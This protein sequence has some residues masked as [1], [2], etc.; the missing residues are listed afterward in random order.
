MTDDRE[1]VDREAPTPPRAMS[2]ARRMLAEFEASGGRPPRRPWR[3][4][5]AACIAVAAIGVAAVVGIHLLPEPPPPTVRPSPQPPMLVPST[6]LSAP[7]DRREEEAQALFAQATE[8]AEA[9]RWREAARL[10]DRLTHAFSETACVARLRPA[11]ARLRATVELELKPKPATSVAVLPPP[12][13]PLPEPQEITVAAALRGWPVAFDDPL[14]SKACL[15]RAYLFKGQYGGHFH[16]HNGGLAVS[17]VHTNSALWW[18]CAVG[19]RWLVSLDFYGQKG[20]PIVLL[21]GPGIGSHPAVGYALHL[22]HE[23]GA[24]G[25]EL[26]RQGALLGVPL[27]RALFDPT[28]WHHLDVLRDGRRIVLHLDGEP[29]GQWEDPDPLGGALHRFVGLAAQWGLWGHDRPHYRH[30]A[31]RV[32]EDE[33]ERLAKHPH[34]RRLLPPVTTPPQANGERLFRDDFAAGGAER[35]TAVQAADAVNV[36]GGELVLRGPNAWPVAWRDEPVRGS[37]AIEYRMSYFPGGEAVNFNAQLCVGQY[38]DP[39]V[40]GSFCGWRLGFPGG[41]G[42]V[43]LTWVTGRG[44]KRMLARTPYFPPVHGRPYVLRLERSGRVLRAFV[45]DGF[46]L[47]ATR[48]EAAPPDAPV[49]PGVFQIYGGSRVSRVEAWRIDDLR[50]PGAGAGEATDFGPRLAAAGSFAAAFRM[51]ARPLIA[52]RRYK[53]AA[54]VLT[55]LGFRDQFRLAAESAQLAQTDVA[56]L[57]QLWTA[58]PPHDDLGGKTA[59][60]VLALLDA[61]VLG[62]DET[63]LQAALF[64]LWDQRPDPDHALRLL[65]A[66]ADQPAARRYRALAHRALAAP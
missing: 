54:E 53:S 35:W 12:P 7:A 50:D 8:A 59:A 9:G 34:H 19:D 2:P 30:L 41:N 57:M 65:D 5:I 49:Y 66:C 3:G 61:D 1:P 26:R 42:L 29:M 4:V 14:T 24:L 16:I 38:P 39:K 47:E 62:H 11:I 55:K 37:V 32:P 33:A 27:R 46:L 23:G 28:A 51:Q 10:L 40:K 22:P 13:P 60:E 18:D 20:V 15:K 6:R 44:E 58:V 52:K 21:N 31:I 64:L 56:R 48:S 43:H 63:R 17:G 45:N 25:V 36:R